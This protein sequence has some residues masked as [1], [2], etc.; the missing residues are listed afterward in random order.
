MKTPSANDLRLAAL[1]CENNEDT[2]DVRTALQRVAKW[3]DWQA[4]QK[5]LRTVAREQ[6]VP[7]SAVRQAL[8]RQAAKD[9]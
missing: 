9:A 2:D 6:R 8:E 7:V 1:W 3:L 4:D 5:I